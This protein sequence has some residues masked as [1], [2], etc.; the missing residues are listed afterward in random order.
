MNWNSIKVFLEVA[1]FGD[2]K[3]AAKSLGLSHST[4]F[5]QLREFESTLNTRLFE[6]NNGHYE[7]TDAGEALRARARIMAATA[8]D[9]AR[10]LLGHNQRLSGTVR[11]T[12]PNSFASYFLPRYFQ[13]FNEQHPDVEIELL[14]S[15]EEVNLSSRQADIAVRITD[16]PPEY[17]VGRKVCDLRWGLYAAQSQVL[18][19]APKH[20]RELVGQ[21]IIAAA[22]AL[23]NQRAYT[24]LENNLGQNI[25]LR[26]D[27]ISTLAQC[28]QAGVGLAFLPEDL[29]TDGLRKLVSVDEVGTNSLWLLTHADLRKVEKVR[30]LMAFLYESF[31]EESRLLK[32]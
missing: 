1:H 14:V 32:M 19:D 27:D 5:R 9:I 3:Q 24:W 31:T 25:A 13:R 16:N 23:K 8:D 10:E 20:W 2:L 4:V 17:A 7:L 12:A 22:G 26:C 28:A 30:R 29:S 11:V 6:R 21:P 18:N 15:D